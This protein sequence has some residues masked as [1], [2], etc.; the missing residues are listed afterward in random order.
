MA[1]LVDSCVCVDA[2]T[3]QS[4]THN[5]AVR[6]FEYLGRLGWRAAM[7]AHA[8][9]EMQC[10]CQREAAKGN[11]APHKVTIP[12][13]LITM[14]MDFIDRYASG[15]ILYDKSGDHIFLAIAKRDGHILVTY[16]A[17]MTKAA[18]A[19][20]VLA[21]KP[22]ELMDT[23]PSNSTLAAITRPLVQRLVPHRPIIR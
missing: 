9:F 5:E 3:P 4:N 7:P 10:A 11:S 22:S 8:W 16:D 18:K 21:F 23:K 14:D 19:C 1:I 15:E 6:F 13:S 20:G 2:Y 12:A 17:G